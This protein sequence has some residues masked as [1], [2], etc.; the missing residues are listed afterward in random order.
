MTRKAPKKIVKKKITT[1]KPIV[2]KGGQPPKYS[3]AEAIEKKVAE[4]VIY[5]DFVPGK[6]GKLKIRRPT[7]IPNKAGLCYFMGISRETWSQYR[8][9]YPD[10]VK[11]VD[12]WI[13]EVWVQRLKT[14][15]PTGA[16]FYLKNA[17]K[18][19]YKDRH[20]TDITSKGD[21]IESFNE[22]QL[23]RIAGRISNGSAP[24]KT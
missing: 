21:K 22:S 13:E 11:R 15:A 8:A 5:C 7:L 19:V 17:F 16:I 14:N 9:K 23:E 2:N 12:A 10:T 18:E 24:S 20:Q 1:P 4:Y 6:K 3:S